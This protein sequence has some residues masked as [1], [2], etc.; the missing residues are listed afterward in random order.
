MLT[1]LRRDLQYVQTTAFPVTWDAWTENADERGRLPPF[2]ENAAI[3]EASQEACVTYKEKMRKKYAQVTA[4]AQK[5]IG[6]TK[7]KCFPRAALRCETDAAKQRKCKIF[8]ETQGYLFEELADEF[9]SQLKQLKTDLLK[10][11]NDV[12]SPVAPVYDSQT[13]HQQPS[14][15]GSRRG[16][17]WRGNRAGHSHRGRSRGGGHAGRANQSDDDQPAKKRKT[18]SAKNDEN[19]E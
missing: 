17:G 5:H 7:A 15:G 8:L 11:I 14:S 13:H 4:Y 2:C 16:G 1:P 9:D 6:S 10:H 3:P 19:D 12:K 18:E